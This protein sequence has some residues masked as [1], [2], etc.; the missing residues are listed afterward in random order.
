MKNKLVNK[1]VI[2]AIS[3][4]LSAVMAASPVSAMAADNSSV[5]MSDEDQQEENNN[6]DENVVSQEQMFGEAKDALDDALEVEVITDV[7]AVLTIGQ[8]IISKET[9]AAI[10]DFNAKKDVIAAEEAIAEGEENIKA[11]DAVRTIDSREPIVAWIASGCMEDSQ[12][13][14]CLTYSALLYPDC[15]ECCGYYG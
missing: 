12:I 14:R 11:I 4:G 15:P 9:Q 3:I 2:K 6:V 10:A 8:G 5:E 13:W 7:E 1:Q